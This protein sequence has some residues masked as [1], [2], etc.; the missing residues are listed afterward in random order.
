MQSYTPLRGNLVP[1]G[2]LCISVMSTNFAIFHVI[3]EKS[4]NYDLLRLDYSGMFSLNITNLI[5][6][7]MLV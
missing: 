3:V 7:A 5:C 4:S 1:E 6:I 2:T